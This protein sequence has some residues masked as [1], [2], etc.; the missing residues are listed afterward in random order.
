MVRPFVVL[1]DLTALRK[2]LFPAHPGFGGWKRVCPC[3][4]PDQ[5]DVFSSASQVTQ[6]RPIDHWRCECWKMEDSR[7]LR[8]WKLNHWEQSDQQHDVVLPVSG[9]SAVWKVP[10]YIG[11]RDVV[12]SPM[13][14]SRGTVLLQ[15]PRLLSL[16]DCMRGTMIEEA[17]DALQSTMPI[18]CQLCSRRAQQLTFMARR[19]SSISDGRA[20]LIS[21]AAGNPTYFATPDRIET[22]RLYAVWCRI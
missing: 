22:S 1:Q 15:Q 3:T 6:I 16:C 18:S 11:V 8:S 4:L 20:T 21:G 17:Q 5:L 12:D 10:H 14:C 2:A 9:S 19:S 13:V 7:L